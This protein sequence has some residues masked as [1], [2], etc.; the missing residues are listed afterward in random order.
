MGWVAAAKIAAYVVGAGTAV[1]AAVSSHQQQSDARKEADRRAQ[2]ELN[3]RKQLASQ[4]KAPTVDREGDV[5]LLS[6][7]AA[8]DELIRRRAKKSRLR[9]QRSQALNVGT[10]GT[11]SV[12]TGLKVG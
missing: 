3:L 5:E 9:V 1:G 4:A 2:E 10:S 6:E 8:E 7:E 12:G 11:P